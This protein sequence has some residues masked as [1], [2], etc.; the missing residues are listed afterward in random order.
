MTLMEMDF[1]KLLA[2]AEKFEEFAKS[3]PETLADAKAI[4]Q[5]LDGI[6][7]E[8]NPEV[9]IRFASGPRQQMASAPAKAATEAKPAAAPV[10][11]KAGATPKPTPP[12]PA[13]RAV[14]AKNP[15]VAKPEPASLPQAGRRVYGWRKIAPADAARHLQKLVRLTDDRGAAHKGMLTGLGGGNITL[16]LAQVDG[17]GVVQIP[18]AEVR[19]LKVFDRGR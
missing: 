5:G 19:E 11:R 8:L 3:N 10:A 4:M 13:A 9:S 12:A 2:N 15:T 18:L 7:A 14:V 6:K 17:G 1:G 16:A